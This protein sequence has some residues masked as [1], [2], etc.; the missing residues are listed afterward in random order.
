MKPLPKVSV[1]IPNYNHAAFVERRIN[2]VLHQTYLNFEVIILDDYSSDNSR[3]I[4]NQYR[5]HPKIANIILND[6]NSGSPFVQWKKGLEYASGDWIWIAET[7]D[8]AELNFLEELIHKALEHESTGLVFSDSKA[9]NNKGELIEGFLF[10]EFRNK[11]LN[12]DHWS[13]DYHNKGLSEV[14][15]YLLLGGTINNTSA[16][17]FRRDILIEANPFDKKFR[18]IGD[19]YAFVKVLS[20]SDVSYVNKPLNYY[21][22]NFGETDFGNN[23]LQYCYEQFVIF[24]WV[25]K[26]KNKINRTKFYKAFYHN[27]KVSFY[28]GWT[29]NKMKTF[30]SLASINFLLFIDFMRFNLFNPILTR[31]KW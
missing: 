24:N 20:L 1:I 12:T 31:F 15:D 23:Q 29:V 18:F 19:K 26:G 21:K 5:Q 7:D 28:K 3:E 13:Q 11:T 8:Y 27:M 25:L 30:K 9:I 10:S 2:T 17:L 6:T 14:E 22:V 4:I 16:V